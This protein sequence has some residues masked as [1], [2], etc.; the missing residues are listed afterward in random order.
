MAIHQSAATDGR[1]SLTSAPDAYTFRA[2]RSG[3]LVVCPYCNADQITR[4]DF[5]GDEGHIFADEFFDG[6]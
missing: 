2:P 6:H 5:C 3:D 1:S 4:C